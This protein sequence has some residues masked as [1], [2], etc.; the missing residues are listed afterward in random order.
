M[1]MRAVLG[2]AVPALSLA[3]AA[4]CSKSMEPAVLLPLCVPGATAVS[5]SAG[6]T[7]SVNWSPACRVSFLDVVSFGVSQW[8][9]T[10][11]SANLITPPVQYGV[12]PS[13]ARQIAAPVILQAGFNYSVIIGRWIG[14]KATDLEN[15]GTLAFMP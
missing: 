8:R 7:P 13:G 10:S 3:L 14:P 15:V 4:S 5:V 1:R 6:V 11:D 2:C 9:V 12:V